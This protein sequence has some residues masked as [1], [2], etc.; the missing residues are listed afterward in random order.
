MKSYQD[1]YHRAKSFFTSPFGFH[2]IALFF[3]SLAIYVRSLPYEF[4]IF[5]DDFH[6]LSNQRIQTNALSGL[7]WLWSHSMM[8]VTY[9]VW[10][11]I[12]HAFN[13]TGPL[14]FRVL[15][16]GLHIANC[17]LIYAFLTNFFSYFW[18]ERR[19]EGALRTAA[20][21]GA[22][23]FAVHPVHVENVAWISA[24]KDLLSTFFFLLALNKYWKERISSS[25]NLQG[26]L[27][28]FFLIFLAVLS[29]PSALVAPLLLIVLDF[30]VFRFSLKRLTKIYG[31]FIVLSLL[32]FLNLQQVLPKENIEFSPSWPW[33]FIVALNAFKFNFYK[34]VIP[35]NYY[36]DYGYSA[37]KIIQAAQTSWLNIVVDLGFFVVLVGITCIFIKRKYNRV[38][39]IAFWA[40]LILSLP[41]LGFIPFGFQTISTVADRFLYLPSLAAAILLGNI[42]LNYESKKTQYLVFLALLVFGGVA[43]RQVGY[44]KDSITFLEYSIEQNPSSYY[45]RIA[46]AQAY[47][48]D[49]QLDRARR[50]RTN[51]EAFRWQ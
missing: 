8:P 15:S 38:F 16:V 29:K 22:V 51:A 20:F 26:N 12:G 47:E 6:L 9:S 42:Y 48:N 32:G 49:G 27:T 19:S 28:I 23:L 40:F 44:W 45:M 31:L 39:V 1:L 10:A 7:A 5:D 3:I 46:L 35:F 13:F 36:F 17:G 11:L 18:K 50:T 2:L 43:Y 4:F 34:L 41:S 25:S 33:R 21:F 14:P 37:A 24:T 30:F